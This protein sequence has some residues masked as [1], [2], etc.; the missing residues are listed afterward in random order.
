MI[1]VRHTGREAE[2]ASRR[3]RAARGRASPLGTNIARKL[4]D[5]GL[6]SASETGS[7]GRRPVSGH[8]GTGPC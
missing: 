1:V 7:N 6:T 8:A 3:F 4:L 5:D 2:A